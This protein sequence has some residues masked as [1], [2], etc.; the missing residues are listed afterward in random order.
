[1][2]LIPPISEIQSQIC[3]HCVQYTRRHLMSLISHCWHTFP[4]SW[5]INKQI[6]AETM[7][8]MWDRAHKM[9]PG[10]LN[11]M[12]PP[13]WLYLKY[14]WNEINFSS[15]RNTFDRHY[16]IMI[17]GSAASFPEIETQFPLMSLKHFIQ[18]H[19]MVRDK[20]K[21]TLDWWWLGT[22]DGCSASFMCRIAPL[23]C[24][25]GNHYMEMRSLICLVGQTT[26]HRRAFLL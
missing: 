13:L 17:N 5:L 20:G 24:E 1:M 18:K 12:V 9:A 2:D 14:W 10:I 25:S 7:L 23:L 19:F 8:A 3:Y 22:S 4:Q 15:T 16:V 21:N 11:T 6:L 26:G